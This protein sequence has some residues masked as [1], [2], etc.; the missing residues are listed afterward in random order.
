[1][2]YGRNILILSI[3]FLVSSFAVDLITPIWPVYIRSSLG[4]SMT[5]L[6]FVFSASNAVAAA[7]QILSGFLSDK[8]GRKRLHI[9]GTLLAVFSPLMY[10]LAS[11]WLDLVPWVMLSGFAI[12]LYLP[13][14]WVIVADVSSTETM[15]SAYSWINISWLVGS[16][17][18][19]FVGGIAADLFSIRIPFF[20]CF[21]LRL[22]VVPLTFLLQETRR[23]RQVKG[24]NYENEQADM[25]DKYLLTVVLF[26][27][28]NI[29]QG[30]GI[31]VT[32]P[33]IPVFV[34]SNFQADFTFVGIL[35]AIGFGFA[36]II[37]QIPGGKCSDLFDRRKVMVVTFIASSP[38]FLLFAYSRNTLELIVFMFLSRVILNLSWSPFQTLMMDA[39]PSSK[40]GLINGVSA[41]TFWMGALIGNVFSGI[42]WDSWGMLAPFYVSSFAIGLSAL[43]PLMLK[44]TRGKAKRS[45]ATK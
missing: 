31:G 14:R 9:M 23:K 37:A 4:A 27:L 29:I 13:I 36:S 43:L 11:N 5:E 2:V 42:L 21:V 26:S 30:V 22:A 34:V 3:I 39:T 38:F 25:I 28:I 32:Q 40:W 17:V 18:A 16:T 15:A 41:A 44:E 10:A 12:G 33:A 7:T 1:M 24:V 8:Y 6:G 35:Y 20:T 45:S 19:P